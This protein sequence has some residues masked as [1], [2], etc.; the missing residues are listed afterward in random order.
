MGTEW[1]EAGKEGGKG[2][3]GDRMRTEGENMYKWRASAFLGG[4]LAKQ[5]KSKKQKK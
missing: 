3:R 5:C 1:G 2:R 4:R